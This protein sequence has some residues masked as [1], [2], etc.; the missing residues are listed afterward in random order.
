MTEE[1]QPKKSEVAARVCPVCKGTG[2]DKTSHRRY[3]TGG[4]DDRSCPRCHGECYIE[5]DSSTSQNQDEGATT[6]K[7]TV[8]E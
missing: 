6:G 5:V 1:Q 8:N 4:H 7:E 3:T 2:L